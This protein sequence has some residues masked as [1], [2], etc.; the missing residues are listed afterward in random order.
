MKEN[1]NGFNVS[2]YFLIQGAIIIGITFMNSF[3]VY[4]VKDPEYYNVKKPDL[5]TVLGNLTFV[6]ELFILPSHLILGS[7]MDSIGRKIPTVIG[8]IIA[9]VC[10]I[11]IPEEHSSVFPTLYILRYFQI[12]V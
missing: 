11:L 9:G 6:A 5:G 10:I 1:V 2:T 4:I 7:I 8:I 12:S 3:L